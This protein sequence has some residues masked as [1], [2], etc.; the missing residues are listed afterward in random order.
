MRCGSP[1]KVWQYLLSMTGCYDLFEPAES[2]PYL[3]LMHDN[4]PVTPDRLSYRTNE[5]L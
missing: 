3:L 5:S 1:P 2:A 4:T